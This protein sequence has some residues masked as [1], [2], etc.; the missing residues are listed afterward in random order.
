[1]K[2]LYIGH[3]KEFGGWS[4]AAKDYILALD[5]F[6]VDV[7]CRNVTL[8]QDREVSGRLKELE[9]KAQTVVISVFNMYYHTISSRQISLRRI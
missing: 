9:E 1:M 5:A 6:G 3:Y 2:I 8:T 7:V 4:Q